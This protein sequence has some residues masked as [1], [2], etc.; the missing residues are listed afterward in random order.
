VPRASEL[1]AKSETVLESFAV[2]LDA[3]DLPVR[4]VREGVNPDAAQD[5]KAS[6]ERL[7]TH[8]THTRAV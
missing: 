4:S 2:S 5:I 1:R 3:L 6:E 7:D 8:E